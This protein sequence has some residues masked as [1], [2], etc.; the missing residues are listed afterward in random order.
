MKPVEHP[1]GQAPAPAPE[2]TQPVT[3]PAQDR[4]SAVLEWSSRASLAV[5]AVGFLLY[6]SGVLPPLVPTETLPELWGLPVSQ[7]L[8]ATG[9]PTGWAWL[10]Q[11]G[12]GDMIGELGVAMLALCSLP[13]VLAL[14]PV[15]RRSN[16][17]LY[18]ALCIAQAAVLVLSASGLLVIH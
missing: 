10:G 15:Y 8:A 2:P 17:R 18:I 16:D 14:L 1:P 6:L 7:F 4:Y 13:C 12:H 3:T 11:L 9:A 5:M